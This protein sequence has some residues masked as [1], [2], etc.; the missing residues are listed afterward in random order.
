MP[1]RSVR[2][3]SLAKINLDLRVLNKRPDGF[4]ELRSIFQ[5][6]SLADT[7][8]LAFTPQRTTRIDLDSDI[9]IPNNLITRAAEQVLSASHATGHLALRLR[10]KIPM[11]GGLGGGSG[12]AAAILLALPVLTGKPLSLDQR[13]E[14]ASGLGSDVPFFLLGGAAL[15]LGRGTELYPLPEPPARPALI[16]LPPVQVSTAEAYRN[17]NRKLTDEGPSRTIRGFQLLAWELGE[18]E[19]GGPWQ[20][21]NDFETVVFQQHPQLGSIKGKLLK[22]GAQPALMSGSGSTLFG[23]F[24]NAQARAHAAAQ[25][26]NDFANIQVHAVSLVPR[27]RYRALWWR[28]LSAHLEGRTWPPP[29]RYLKR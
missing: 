26:R 6:I 8:E 3:R 10:K 17:L 11:G 23:I 14:L 16:V 21:V 24:P 12:N 18:R 28:Q 9:D 5:T 7:I 2:V 4:H 20:P 1:T 15:G 13:M 27:S 22:L 29:S 19:P 25:L